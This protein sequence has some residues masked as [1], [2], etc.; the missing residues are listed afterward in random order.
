MAPASLKRV[1]RLPGIRYLRPIW[2]PIWSRLRNILILPASL[3]GLIRSTEQRALFSEAQAFVKDLPRRL[4]EPLPVA[5]KKLDG[6]ISPER[7]SSQTENTTRNL[8]DL[9]ILLHRRS[10][11]GICMRRSLTRYYFL[12]RAG[13]P[14]QVHFGARFVHGKPDREITGHAW[15]T[16][17]DKPYHE[18]GKNWRGF[19]VMLSFPKEN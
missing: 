16:L 5:I 17:D 11:L 10:P 15:L 6:P 9:A 14:L 4:Q 2:W 3:P 1:S 12:R 13:L 8:A 19:T 7:P 18:P